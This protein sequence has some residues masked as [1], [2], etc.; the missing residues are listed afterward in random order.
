MKAI[1]I[2]CLATLVGGCGLSDHYTQIP[3]PGFL[4]YEAPKT[5]DQHYPDVLALAKAEGQSL[6]GYRPR[7]IEISTR[8]YSV[9]AKAW[10][11]CARAADHPEMFVIINRNGFQERRR[12]APKDGCA[13]LEYTEVEFN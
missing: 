11:I 4:R 13:G 5:P 6:F 10:A 9:E 1:W 3:V 7:R 12:S 8:L 2:A